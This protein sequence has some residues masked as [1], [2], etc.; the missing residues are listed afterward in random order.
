MIQWYP[1][2]MAKTK[3]NIEA[4]LALVDMMIEVI[5]A[6]IP[7]ASRNPD[8]QKYLHKKEHLLVLNKE[9]LADP[10]L[11]RRWLD[12]YR[13]RG[14]WAVAV[15]SARKQGIRE[16]LAVVEKAMR[17]MQQKLAAKGRLPR[18]VRA[19]VIGIPNCGKS[20][21]INALAPSAAAKTGNKPGV[22]RGSQW[23]KT[24]CSLEL[25]DT[26]GILWPKFAD[27]D[28][29]FKLAIC[30]SISD[31]VFPVYQVACQLAA[32]LAQLRPQALQ[33][34][35]KLAQLPAEPELILS[36]IA[37]SRGLLGAGGKTR[38]DDAA[39]LL[40]QEFRAAK[41]GRYTLDTAPEARHER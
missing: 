12:Y 37:A 15:N 34:R 25:L 6:R 38:D 10:Q 4:D 7:A 24:A 28:T 20:T 40:I 16:L 29:A 31:T 22:T 35:Y 13:G 11:T 3:R 30:G 41:I 33:E 17:P 2:H 32:L 26:P 14:Y 27:D 21:V 9:D 19:M 1:G 18:A 23:I 39:I 36:A 8:L 5:D